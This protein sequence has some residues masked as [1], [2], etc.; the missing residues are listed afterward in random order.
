MIKGRRGL[1][2]CLSAAPQTD[3]DIRI[4]KIGDLD[5]T[6]CCGLQNKNTGEVGIIKIQRIDTHKNG[7]RIHFLCGYPA[8]RWVCTLYGNAMHLMQ[9]LNCG[10]TELTE[11]VMR[12]RGEIL[13][14][15]DQRQ[16]LLNRLAASE[17]SDLLR[18]APRTGDIAVVRRI[19]PDTTQ[20]EMKQLFILLTGQKGIA[21]LLGG[22]TYAGAFL[23]FGC[24]KAEKRID[25]RPAF[26]DAIAKIGG[27]G[28]GGPCYA[29]GFGLDTEQLST[30]VETAKEIIEK[31]LTGQKE[32]V[33]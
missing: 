20:E 15:K 3:K 26:Q 8:L 10:E 29:Q 13:E 12:Q 18:N 32:A 7:S 6:P 28:G 5:Y 16:T 22:R 11:R 19:L 25:V 23:M 33:L 27:K 1:V 17:A 4:V 21:V 9:E 14:L 2:T 31:Q 30:A 24:N